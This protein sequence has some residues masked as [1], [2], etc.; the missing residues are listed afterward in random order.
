MLSTIRKLWN[1]RIH[2]HYN[3]LAY[4]N[5][6]SSMKKTETLLN[7]V[8][9]LSASAQCDNSMYLQ[10]LTKQTLACMCTSTMVL[11]SLVNEIG[12]STSS[13]VLSKSTIDHQR[14]RCR[15]E[16][17]K[18]IKD[19]FRVCKSVMHWDGKLL[20]DTTG[21]HTDKVDRLPV[22]ISSVVDGST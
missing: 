6:V 16:A 20:H 1:N 3:F 18:Q 19:D 2:K 10:Y 22:L 9:M 21:V 14:Q 5:K 17:A 11:A 4:V 7:Q 13:A 15:T 12:W 8:T